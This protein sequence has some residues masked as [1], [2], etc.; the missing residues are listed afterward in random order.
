M[1]RLKIA[2]IFIFAFL[3]MC[4]Q[5]CGALGIGKQNRNVKHDDSVRIEDEL[6]KPAKIKRAAGVSSFSVR[7]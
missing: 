4:E 6:S 2:A 3:Y 1:K 7:V 5:R